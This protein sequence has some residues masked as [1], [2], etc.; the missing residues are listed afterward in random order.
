MTG[1]LIK[2]DED[3]DTWG[4]SSGG[5]RED[6]VSQGERPREDP[7]CPHLDL[8]LPA[9]RIVEKPITVALNAPSLW[10]CY[11]AMLT[12]TPSQLN[13]SCMRAKPLQWC[14]TLCDPMDCSPPGSCPWNFAGK[15]LGVGCHSL[16]QGTFS[17]QG[18]D[19]SHLHCR[20][21]LHH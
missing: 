14:L 17:T 8:Q 5:S 16:L 2:G 1:V 13:P 3:A 21:I 20:W 11:A 7:A 4:G 15:N 18:L 19:Q 6:T 10:F 9:S 12:D